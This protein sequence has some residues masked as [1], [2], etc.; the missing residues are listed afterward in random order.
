[1]LRRPRPWKGNLDC[2]RGY[3]VSGVSRPTFYFSDGQG[4]IPGKAG[5][6]TASQASWAKGMGTKL[7]HQRHRICGGSCG[8][9]RVRHDDRRLYKS[10]CLFSGKRFGIPTKSPA[11]AWEKRRLARQKKKKAKK[12]K[13]KKKKKGRSRLSFRDFRKGGMVR[14]LRRLRLLKRFQRGRFAVRAS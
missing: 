9:P 1:M 13:K 8:G 7:L 6:R 5:L 10:G 14:R 2:R 12:K 4:S 3:Q 11:A